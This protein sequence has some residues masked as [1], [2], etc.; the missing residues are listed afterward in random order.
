MSD[1]IEGGCLCGAIRYR[2]TS[3]PIAATLCHC[4]S[5]RLATGAP[6][7]AWAVF[8]KEDFVFVSG[9]PKEFS[10]SPDVVRS[11][12][13]TCGTPLTYRRPSKANTI[14]VT[15]ATLDAA[16]DFAPAKEIWVEEKLAWECLNDRMPHYARSSVG[17]T[18]IVSP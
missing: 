4:K 9:Q 6:S 7:V 11:F 17:A 18:P 3:A 13:D 5:C 8:R 15:A 12:C 16:G 2:A 1:L 14:D 10:S